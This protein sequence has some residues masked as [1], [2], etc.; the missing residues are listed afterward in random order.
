MFDPPEALKR[1]TGSPALFGIVQGLLSASLYFVLGVV[2]VNALGFSWLV[3]LA[4]S[5]FFVLL[6][7]SYMEGA[8]L[9][10]ERGGATVIARFGFNELW[11]FVAGWAILLDYLILIAITA[12]ATTDYAAVFWGELAHGVP[13]LGLSFAVIAYVAFVNLRGHGSRRWDR[14]AYAVAADVLVQLVIVLLG[15]A[16]VFEPEVLTDPSMPAGTPEP[17]GRPLRVHAGHRR[18]LGPRRLVGARRR[19]RRVAQG[20]AAA[21]RRARA[22][23]GRALHRHR[24][25]RLGHA[26]ADRRPLGGGADGGHRLLASTRPG[27]ASRCATWSPSR[28]SSSS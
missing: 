23:R 4:A 9:H 25:R 26:A 24:A 8:S 16:L 19:G 14:A 10:Q 5:L 11:S 20:A 2:V 7:L 3:Y 28:R 12:F 21:A 17:G 18:L 22:G 6:V 13:E 1:G 15:L 27:C